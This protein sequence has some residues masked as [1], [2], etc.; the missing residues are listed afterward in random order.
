[1]CIAG[2]NLDK[3]LVGRC[4]RRIVDTASI[5]QSKTVLTPLG[6]KAPAVVEKP[7][8]VL[9]FVLMSDSFRGAVDNN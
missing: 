9:V 2:D 4:Q 7:F 8:V 1:M 6:E 3:L 5:L